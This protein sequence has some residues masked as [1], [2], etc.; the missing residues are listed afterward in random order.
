MKHKKIKNTKCLM[1]VSAVDKNEGQE[2]KEGN[3]T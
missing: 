2:E 1:L 3:W